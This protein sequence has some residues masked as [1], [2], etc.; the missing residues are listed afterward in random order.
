MSALQA[1]IAPQTMVY[2]DT[3]SKADNSIHNKVLGDVRSG[4]T[5]LYLR[6]MPKLSLREG[7]DKAP[8]GTLAEGRNEAGRTIYFGGFV[9]NE[10]DGTPEGSVREVA[11][12]F[13]G[14]DEGDESALIRQ[15]MTAGLIPQ[16]SDSFHKLGDRAIGVIENAVDEGVLKVTSDGRLTVGGVGAPEDEIHTTRSQAYLGANRRSETNR[17]GQVVGNETENTHFVSKGQRSGEVSPPTKVDADGSTASHTADIPTQEGVAVD[18]EGTPM[19]GNPRVLSTGGLIHQSENYKIYVSDLPGIPAG[20]MVEIGQS[21]L[22]EAGLV[23]PSLGTVQLIFERGQLGLVYPKGAS[24]FPIAVG[25]NKDTLDELAPRGNTR[26]GI[27]NQAF[28]R[29][30]LTHHN[31]AGYLVKKENEPTDENAYAEAYRVQLSTSEGG[32]YLTDRNGR[33]TPILPEALEVAGDIDDP[34]I[35]DNGDLA[36]LRAKGRL[37]VLTVSGEDRAFGIT[38]MQLDAAEALTNLYGQQAIQAAYQQG[39]LGV[40]GRH[41]GTVAILQ[42]GSDKYYLTGYSDKPR[43]LDADHPYLFKPQAEPAPR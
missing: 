4:N 11:F 35:I 31:G 16:D 38:Q 2:H 33:K 14:G 28:Q 6:S 23:Q 21:A 12:F 19:L 8:W 43:P 26:P 18:Q 3:H 40:G 37:V 32:V 15:L 41:L 17:Q 22:R 34:G 27:L 7:L 20:Q 13:E 36:K 30:K 10:L 1:P 29:G 5:H 42:P 24:G 39:Y 9:T 25:V